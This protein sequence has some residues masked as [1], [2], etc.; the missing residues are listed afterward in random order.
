MHDKLFTGRGAEKLTTTHSCTESRFVYPVP[1]TEEHRCAVFTHNQKSGPG[2][3][4]SVRNMSAA[5]ASIA[6]VSRTNKDD[7]RDRNKSGKTDGRANVSD[8]YS[9]SP[10]VS[11]T[12]H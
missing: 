4:L 12:L 5:T 7:S 2:G 10:F 9:S 8:L 1:G 6:D 3:R 11:G